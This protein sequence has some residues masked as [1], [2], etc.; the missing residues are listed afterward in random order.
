MTLKTYHDILDYFRRLVGGTR[1]EGHIFAVGGCVR[2]EFLGSE[3]HDVDI[4]VDLP[5]GGVDFANWL[6]KQKQVTGRPVFFRKFGTARIR[7]R[8]F[9]YEEIELVQTRAEKYTDRTSRCPE[10]VSGD[11]RDDCFRRDFTVNTLYKN[12]STGEILDLTGKAF[13]DIREGVLRTPLDPYET[14]DDDPVRILR[15]LRF[16]ARFGWTI[17]PAVM[18]ALRKSVDRLS[19]VSRERWAAEFSKM[20]LGRNVGCSIGVLHQIGGLQ[21]MNGLMREMSEKRP[22]PDAPTLLETAVQAVERLEEEGVDDP[23]EKYA[24]FFGNIGMLRTGVVDRHG[25]LRYPRHEHTGSLMA[26][27]MLK[28]LGVEE[29]T[30]RKAVE[31]IRRRGEERMRLEKKMRMDRQ[32]AELARLQAAKRKRK[33]ER[34][35][36]HQALLQE[37][38]KAKKKKDKSSE[39]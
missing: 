5:D 24:A 25:E 14:F 9:P 2:D 38:A 29:K 27:R 30:A 13:H 10:V 21:L 6:I 20:I 35:R 4:A 17:D 22:Y 8:R 1:W 11:I 3:I 34:A 36:R 39:P 31:I 32:K 28:R 19:I 23:A 33:S 16:A 18:E 12:I 15:C 26:A 7:L 37:Q